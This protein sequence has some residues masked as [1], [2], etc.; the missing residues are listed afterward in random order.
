MTDQLVP[1]NVYNT[2]PYVYDD[3]GFSTY[4]LE[5]TPIYFNFL[6]KNGW[7][8]RRI[9]DLGCGTGISVE[10]FSRQR[11]M[12]TGVDVSEAMIEVARERLENASVDATLVC[13]D[14]RRY[15]PIE[16]AFDLIISIGDV[17]NYI[18]SVRDL[19]GIFQRVNHGLDMGRT[20]LFDLR[21]VRSLAQDFGT[22]ELVNKEDLYVVV[23]NRY[24]YETQTLGQ[25]FTFFYRDEAHDQPNFLRAEENHILRGYPFRAVTT[26]LTRAGFEV[27]HTLDLNLD[28]F[29]PDKDPHG[30]VV[31]VA[32]K[33]RDLT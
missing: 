32:E 23:R 8:G 26:M 6:Q 33:T 28:P 20:F 22:Q 14:L 1:Q 27:K 4:A 17:M 16:K 29:D 15:T 9:L 31:I 21:T 30:R 7:I 18:A 25:H 2:L 11:M 10:F 12:T 3:A 5:Y 19:E 24:D 13:E